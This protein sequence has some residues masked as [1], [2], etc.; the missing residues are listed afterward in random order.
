MKKRKEFALYRLGLCPPD[1]LPSVEVR[2]N[3]PPILT[4]QRADLKNDE[5]PPKESISTKSKNSFW[6]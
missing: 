1:D 3:N 6:R 4:T 5:S 2:Y